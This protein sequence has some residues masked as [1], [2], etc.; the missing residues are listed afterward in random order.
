[1]RQRRAGGDLARPLRGE[2]HQLEPVRDLDHTI[3]DG[4]ARHLFD[5]SVIVKLHNIWSACGSAA[6]ALARSDWRA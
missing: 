5:S 6:T 2:Q 3:F 4:N 1:M